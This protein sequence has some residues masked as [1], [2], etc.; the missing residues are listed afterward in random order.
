MI[1]PIFGFARG[2]HIARCFLEI[3]EHLFAGGREMGTL[4]LCSLLLVLKQRNRTE[5]GGISE[6]LEQPSGESWFSLSS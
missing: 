6:D 3:L 5:I 4:I 2:F 1:S